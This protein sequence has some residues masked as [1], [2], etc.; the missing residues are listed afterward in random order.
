MN[1]V[2]YINQEEK[3]FF[4]DLDYNEWKIVPISDEDRNNWQFS[5]KKLGVWNTK[6]RKNR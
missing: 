3:D 5:I 4:G 2:K 1:K 6:K